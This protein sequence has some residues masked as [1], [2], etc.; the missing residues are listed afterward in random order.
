MLGLSVTFVTLIVGLR[1]GDSETFNNMLKLGLVLQAFSVLFGVWLQFILMTAPI[2]DI[3]RAYESFEKKN[4]HKKD[5]LIWLSRNPTAVQKI[6]FYS[7]CV[8]FL[9]AFIVVVCSML[10]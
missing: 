2:K 3:K 6:C 7:Q 5:E 1:S 9:S 4:T 8:T 10:I